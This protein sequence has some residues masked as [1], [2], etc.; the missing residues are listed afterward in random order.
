MGSEMCIRDRFYV[1]QRIRDMA[2]A[3]DGRLILA[4]DLGSLIIVNR[5]EK[6]IP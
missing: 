5:T 4:G 2:V 1:D 6:D 3:G